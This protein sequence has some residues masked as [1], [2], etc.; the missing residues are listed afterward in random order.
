M[1]VA[2]GE[3]ED[4]PGQGDEKEVFHLASRQA[5]SIPPHMIAMPSKIPLS[6][7]LSTAFGGNDDDGVSPSSSLPPNARAQYYITLAS[8]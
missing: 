8:I 4:V 2:G 5:S 3:H 7:I 1:D 6:P